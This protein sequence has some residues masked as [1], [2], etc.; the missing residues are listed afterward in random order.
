ML[1]AEKLKNY[2]P[3][4]FRPGYA[5]VKENGIHGTYGPKARIIYSRTPKVINGMNHITSELEH[6]AY[7]M[8]GELV[9]PGLDF[10]TSSGRIRDSYDTPEAEFRI[11][12]CYIPGISF[13]ARLAYMNHIRDLYFLAHPCIKFI[14]YIPVDT[15][16]KFSIIC[17]TNIKFGAEGTCWIASDH[18]YQPGK[19]GWNWM[20]R[21]PFKSCEATVYGMEA[22]TKD[23]KYEQSLGALLCRLDNDIEFKCGIFK[24]Q[25]DE[26]RQEQFDT[27]DL[28]GK[29]IT[30]EFKALS[31]YG[32]PTQPRYK[33]ERWDL[34]S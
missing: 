17:R 4:R 19:R 5:S 22:G 26:W 12:N 14:Q 33:G 34:D 18:V 7:P 10:E 11:F 24:G 13:D 32:K 30:V 20:K 15:I 8:M 23:K 31:K 21:V 3:K 25:T 9:I 1:K 28:V 2:D 6:L 16:E 29:R 27:L